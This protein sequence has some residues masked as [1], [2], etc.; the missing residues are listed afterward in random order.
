MV[1]AFLDVC[2]RLDRMVEEEIQ[3]YRWKVQPGVFKLRALFSSMR[4]F[5]QRR[6]E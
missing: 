5:N 3:G 1:M 6:I 4:G 2:V